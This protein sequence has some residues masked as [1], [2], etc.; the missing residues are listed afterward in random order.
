MKIRIHTVFNALLLISTL[1][2]QLSN[3]YAQGTAF[4]YQGRL[5]SGT[6]AANGSFD[7]TFSLFNVSI[8]GSAVAGP[9]T[10]NAVEVTNGLFT[11]ALD[12]GPDVFNGTAY[13]LEIGV[14]TNGGGS[15]TDLAPRQVLTPSPYAIY[16]ESVTASGIS[17]T[18][19]AANFGG[20]YN[21]TVSFNN[22]ADSFDGS[23][24]GQFYGSTFTG[25]IF[26]GAFVGT[27]SG[28]G[29]VWHTGGNSGTTAGLN[30][31][32]TTDNQ[33]L[34]LHV[35]GLRAFRLEPTT[36][37]GFATS[38]VN[39]IAG[40][41][42]NFAGTGA[43]GVTIAGGG[44]PFYF[45]TGTANR[46]LD[47]FGTIGGGVNNDIETNAYESTIA[48][49]NANSIQPGSFRSTIAGGWADTIGPNAGQSF[50]GGGQNNIIQ[51]NAGWAVIVG[52]YFNTNT[53]LLSFIG[54]GAFN[55]VQPG[56]GYSI[57][58]GGYDN[59]IHTNAGASV[60]VGGEF[61]TI[62]TNAGSSVIVGGLYNSVY[63]NSVYGGT[64]ST[65][66]GGNNNATSGGGATVAG[67]YSNQATNSLATVGGGYANIASGY[68]SAVA[69]GEDST[70]SGVGAFVGGGGYDNNFFQGNVAG[71]NG[72]TI[73]GGVG[74]S[75]QS[76]AN[77]SFIGGGYQNA[78][79]AG[80]GYYAVIGG[81]EINTNT[82]F[83]SVIVGGAEN[84]IL[85]SQSDGFIGGGFL[86][87]LVGTNRLTYAGL[88]S[89]A[90]NTIGGGAG[91]A[92]LQSASGDF[93]GSGINNTI[94]TNV[95]SSVVDGGEFNTIQ[96]NVTNSI[97]L[98]GANNQVT[99]SYSAAGGEE[100][101]AGHA[102]SFVWN[103]GSTFTASIVTNSVTFR[104]S[105]GY[106]FF[107]GNS[108]AGAQL[109]AGATSWTAIS[110]RNAKKNFKPVDAVAVL[111]KLA[112]IPIEQWN[113]KWEKDTDVPNL[114]PM[115]QDFK[116]AFY[117]GRDDKGISTLEFD[118]V[119]LAAIQG[120]NQK[121][122]E[123]DAEIQKLKEKADRVDSLEKR[124]NALEQVVQSL[125]ANQ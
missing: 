14:R 6:S 5:N 77:D 123:K 37:T 4:T 64:G 72:S 22:G 105:G 74:N 101:Y 26:T 17:G 115:A 48:G 53:G 108:S 121:L 56:S 3:V 85:S 107:T 78:I 90:G 75:I 39:I 94:Q 36:N 38:A 98:G 93:I 46:V 1:S 24:Y 70:A 25:G 69:G 2:L 119:E 79:Q 100:A 55:S 112:A 76:G 61:N 96:A 92:I 9:L 114:G 122:N 32:G 87:Q 117:P 71:G 51:S 15:F 28:L 49:G 45:G 58:G 41:P 44:A 59:T 97:I 7:L 34:E 16:A 111:D 19:P 27:G 73:G 66:G 80:S 47:N 35:N 60:I 103:D 43:L 12:F 57:I 63:Y 125:A 84:N 89:G 65:I 91:N 11:V 99:A 83:D 54:T 109:I 82:G 21:N 106:R 113:Y 13:W 52:G 81:G 10:T 67:G 42:A 33:P 88:G 18:I 68:G 50:I 31:V 110:D 120:L 62:Q 86:N 40:S 124:L 29:D 30:F 118:G 104:A 8:G 102:N 20:S 23:F 116:R 95:E